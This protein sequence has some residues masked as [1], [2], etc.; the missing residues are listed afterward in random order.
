MA[1]YNLGTVIHIQRVS[2]TVW[3]RN[4][5]S[6]TT[7]S[8]RLRTVCRFLVLSSLLCFLLMTGCLHSGV[9]IILTAPLVV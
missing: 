2:P 9:V 5:S 6:T 3:H 8:G 1:G 4:S 7:R